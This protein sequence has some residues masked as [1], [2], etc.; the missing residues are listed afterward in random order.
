MISW[1]TFM[2]E[3][4]RIIN[5]PQCLLAC[6]NDRKSKSN[7]LQTEKVLKGQIGCN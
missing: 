1:W 2:E 5:D 7:G 4:E 6:Q 3:S